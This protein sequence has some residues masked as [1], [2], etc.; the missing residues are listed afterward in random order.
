MHF[1]NLTT[2][3]R[4]I[5]K[6]KAYKRKKGFSNQKVV[7]FQ[8]NKRGYYSFITFTIL[9]LITLCAE[10]VANNKPLLVYH[11]GGV[12]FP[13]MSFYSEQDFG[14]EFETEADFSDPYVRNLIN[15]QGGFFLEPLIPFSYDTIDLRE[16]HP[17]PAPPSSRHLLGTDDRQRDVLARAIYGFRISVLF[18]LLLTF[19]ASIVGIFLGAV[20]G[21]FGGKIDLFTQ[22]FI[23][24]WN[25]MPNLYILII[26]SSLLVPG[27]WTLLMIMILFSWTALTGVVRAEFLR[28]R[29]F[30]YI[31]AARSMGLSNRKIMFQHILPSGMTSALSM[32]PF[33]IS[34][35]TVT[36]ASLDFLGLGLPPGSPSLGE[37]I[38]QGKNN[39]ESPW[40]AATSFCV[41]ALMLSLL[42][43]I[44]EGI[45]EAFDPKAN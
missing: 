34:G 3:I 17:A 8:N 14:G 44:G 35:A 16:T 20:Q 19:F 29:N 11:N 4:H 36:L 6:Q 13:I 33:I 37:L 12:Y 45:R 41:M 10:F 39:L 28:L 2:Y 38:L 43:F 26:F 7:R 32:L 1:Q 31:K 18:G 5:R 23:E 21:Y 24:I 9:F 25:A 42:V 40:L 15:D 22:R 30:D 27:F